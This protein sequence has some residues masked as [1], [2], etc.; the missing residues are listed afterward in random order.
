MTGMFNDSSSSVV[1]V[2]G[3]LVALIAFVGTTFLGWKW[4]PSLGEQ[5][6]PFVIGACV[7]V[8]AIA[9]VLREG[10]SAL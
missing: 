4:G 6:V 9:L 1:T 7:A 10:L 2:L 3:I 8:V 5:P